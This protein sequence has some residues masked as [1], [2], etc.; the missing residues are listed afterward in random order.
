[1][2]DKEIQD[3]L[4]NIARRLRVTKIVSTRLIRGTNGEYFTGFAAGLESIQENASYGVDLIHTMSDH[5]VQDVVERG[6]SVQD[7]KLAAL[8]LSWKVDEACHEAAMAGGGITAHDLELKKSQLRSGFGRAV[9]E[10]IGGPS[11]DRRDE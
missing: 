4:I 3:R 7:G 9:R 6:I 5:E 2:N 11:N 10:I 1:M 8:Y